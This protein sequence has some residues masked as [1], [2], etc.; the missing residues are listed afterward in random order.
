MAEREQMNTDERSG[1]RETGSDERIEPGAGAGQQSDAWGVRGTRSF[2]EDIAESE[3]EAGES[4]RGVTANPH[5][6]AQ[7]SSDASENPTEADPSP[8]G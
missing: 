8:S 7:S 6:A 5:S 2:D 1:V 3:S 4:D